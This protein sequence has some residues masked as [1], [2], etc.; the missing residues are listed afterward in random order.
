L[1]NL[2]RLTIAGYDVYPRA[3]AEELGE[4][5]S[6]RT[7]RYLNNRFKQATLL[8]PARVQGFPSGVPIF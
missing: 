1:L 2:D 3:I 7:N 8:S 5:V 6:L 4:E